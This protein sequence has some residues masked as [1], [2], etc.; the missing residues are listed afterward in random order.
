MG[1]F[2]GA[3]IFIFGL[4]VGSFLNVCICRFPKDESILWPSS[5][6]P[7]CNHRLVFFDLIP[8]L[9]FLFLAGRCRYCKEKISFRY[10]VVEFLTALT[11][12]LL[13][14]Y[15]GLTWRL[16]FYFIFS[17]ILIVVSFTDL[18]TYTIHDFFNYL[19]IV[20]GLL[21]SFLNGNIFDSIYGAVIGGLI[22]FLI[23]FIGSLIFKREAMGEGDVFLAIMIGAFLGLKGVIL[24]SYMSFIIGGI[25]SLFLILMRKKNIVEKI[26]FGPYLSIAAV[27]YIFFGVQILKIYFSLLF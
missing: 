7:K 6:C 14:V 15:F 8:I 12:L 11:F 24:T 16:I 27:I 13:Y 21:F 4:N 26:P 1:F 23:R 20:V 22:F 2:I 3:F 10:P 9:S 17:A 18:E 5:H 19:G 25:V